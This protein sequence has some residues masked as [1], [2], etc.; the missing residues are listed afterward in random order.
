MGTAFQTTKSF[1]VMV[2]LVKKVELSVVGRHKYY[3]ALR[4][5]IPPQYYQ[6]LRATRDQ[7]LLPGPPCLY[8]LTTASEPFVPLGAHCSPMLL[9]WLARGPRIARQ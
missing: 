1:A 8:T 2:G 6:A 9:V 3:Q 7:Q 4:T 5:N